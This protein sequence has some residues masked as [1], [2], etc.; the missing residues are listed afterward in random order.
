MVVAPLLRPETRLNNEVAPRDMIDTV[1]Y[2]DRMSHFSRTEPHCP[3]AISGRD[4]GAGAMVFNRTA[5]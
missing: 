2:L 4:I 1:H 3:A 5:H